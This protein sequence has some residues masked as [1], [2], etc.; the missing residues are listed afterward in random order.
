VKTLSGKSS[1]KIGIG[2]YG[3]GGRGHR[4]V[5]ITKK[6]DDK[7]Y[8]EALIYTLNKSINFTE[9]ALGYGH[10]QSLAL[11]KRALDNSKIAREDIFLTHSLYPRDMGSMDVINE[12]IDSFYRVMATDYA[13]S[14]LVTQS[15]I[16]EFGEEPIYSLLRQ[17]L[18]SEKSRY[19]SLSNASPAW[20]RRFKQE[21]GDKFIAHE[22]HLSFEIRALQDKGVFEACEELGIQ[23]IIW[24]PLRQNR[25]LLHD[26]PLLTELSAKY[27]KTPNQ[28][29]LNWICSLG[30]KPMVMSA[31]KS[32]IDENIASTEFQMSDEDHVRIT[33]FRPPNYNPPPVDWE[34]VDGGDQVVVLANQ[35][36]EH[37]ATI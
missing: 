27:Q 8:I 2:S 17:L 30:F 34:G 13:D 19:V 6:D 16:M 28:I 12:D 18:E 9:I 15:L 7:K 22:G 21:F 20:I 24:R 33:N 1:S 29:I 5:D 10:G 14:T 35:F 23:N 36:E 37:L 11:F 26:W 32:H 3:I 25:T 4:D 31:S